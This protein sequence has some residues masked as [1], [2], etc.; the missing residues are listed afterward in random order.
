MKHAAYCLCFLII[1]FCASVVSAAEVLDRFR[2]KVSRFTLNNGITLLVAERH[3][4]PV[5]S[6]VTFVDIGGVDEPKGQTE[7]AHFLKHIAFKGTSEIGT[8]NWESEK[9]FLEKVDKAYS[10][11]LRAK[12]RPKRYSGQKTQELRRQFER[13]RKEAEKYVVPNAY[14]KILERNGATHLNAATSK[15]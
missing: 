5:A 3:R 10:E 2:E 12:Y 1:S 13:L 11:W 15:D 8:R 6:F 4:T 7:I 14:A 9:A